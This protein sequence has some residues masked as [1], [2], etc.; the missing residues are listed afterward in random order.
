MISTRY[1]PDSAGSST[2]SE[3][4]LCLHGSVWC[5]SPDRKQC[6]ILGERVVSR[7][8]GDFVAESVIGAA[9]S[10]NL[11]HVQFCE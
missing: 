2:N 1:P 9:A 5:A 10:A 4:C 6:D 7:E 3:A 8:A 11:M